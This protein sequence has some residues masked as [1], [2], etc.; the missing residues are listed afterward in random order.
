MV[1]LH[2]SVDLRLIAINNLYITDR[3]LITPQTILVGKT[4]INSLV[5]WKHK[6]ATRKTHTHTHTHTLKHNQP[7]EKI[8]ARGDLRSWHPLPQAR[9]C[10]AIT[11]KIYNSCN[12]D[13]AYANGFPDM[14]ED[15]EVV[16]LR[17][18]VTNSNKP[19]GAKQ[20][21]WISGQDGLHVQIPVAFN[22]Q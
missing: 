12:G 16:I 8:T 2:S 21:G 3:P 15:P 13:Y 10:W 5:L 17:I 7:I 9:Q 4:N 6:H 22:A 1:V 11:Q 20:I 14:A 18:C 19:F